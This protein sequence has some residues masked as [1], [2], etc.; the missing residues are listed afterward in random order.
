MFT[1]NNP[2]LPP[3]GPED[4]RKYRM[5][6]QL[7][8]TD[9]IC[10]SCRKAIAR[11]QSEV[12]VVFLTADHCVLVCARGPCYRQA[13]NAATAE[14]DHLPCVKCSTTRSSEW[15]KGM[16]LTCYNWN[17]HQTA[18]STIHTPC[19]RCPAKVSRSWA[20]G[21]CASCYKKDLEQT[22]LSTKHAPC[23]I[24]FK[25]VSRRWSKDGVCSNCQRRRSRTTLQTNLPPC[26]KCHTT[27]DGFRTK[28]KCQVCYDRDYRRDRRAYR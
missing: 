5:K 12:M 18:S 11:G 15:T 19:I 24:C 7:Q 17:R 8:Q 2:G 13:K 6:A 25:T 26:I 20:K 21:L 9:R 23:I 1:K 10:H 28:G 4:E 27:A 14:S 22:T 16:C 3:R